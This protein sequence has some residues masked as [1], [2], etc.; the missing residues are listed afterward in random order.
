MQDEHKRS[1][2]EHGSKIF[3]HHRLELDPP[4]AQIQHQQQSF[5][6][7]LHM[8][9]EDR[10]FK[11]VCFTVQRGQRLLSAVGSLKVRVA[12]T[13]DVFKQNKPPICDKKNLL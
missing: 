8:R 10:G 11:N 12:R 7:P 4:Q 2:F 9:D 5:S 13:W 6:S 1:L 3:G